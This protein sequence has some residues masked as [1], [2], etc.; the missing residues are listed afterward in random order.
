MKKQQQKI[1]LITGASSGIGLC[2]AKFL[3]Q[4]GMKVYGVSRRTV[5]EGFENFCCDVN[6]FAKMKEIFEKI[7]QKEGRIDVLV[8][9][10]GFGIGGALE[11]ASPENIYKLVDTNLSAVLTLSALI[12]PYLKKSKGRLVNIS[13]VGGVIPL[14]YQACYSATKAGVESAS[15]ALANEVKAHG[16]KVIAVLPGDTNTGFTKARVIEA[17]KHDDKVKKV[18]EKTLKKIEKDENSG[19]DPISV[20][21]V[22]YKVIKMKRPPLR[23]SVGFLSKLE[24]FL[25]RIFPTRFVNFIVGKLYG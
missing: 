8:N 19:K 7:Y 1:V 6:D 2:T 14:P 18:E 23:K 11:S 25:V 5:N 9:N 3:M 17:S 13:S 10:A 16:V 15:R 20:S 12:M 24:V 22:I 21:K 4:K